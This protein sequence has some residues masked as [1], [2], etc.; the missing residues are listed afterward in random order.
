M[1]SV[2]GKAVHGTLDASEV[3]WWDLP[4]G[5][6]QAGAAGNELSAVCP[7]T[8]QPDLYD[9]TFRF[10]EREPES[11]SLKMYLVGF[12]DRPISCAELAAT[13]ARELG[14][15][16]R[17]TVSVDLVQQVRGGMRLSASAIHVNEEGTPL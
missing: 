6:T 17:C 16:G 1:T 3:E 13:L 7:V 15:A 4:P 10:W 2:L 5:V 14:E 8:R 11:K 9:F 12:R